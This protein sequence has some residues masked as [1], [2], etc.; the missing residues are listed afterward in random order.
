MAE[1][2]ARNLVVIR[3]FR[4]SIATAQ[5]NPIQSFSSA[6]YPLCRLTGSQVALFFVQKTE[7]SPFPAVQSCLVLIQGWIVKEP[8]GM[9]KD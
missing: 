5:I 7:E 6:V 1:T 2:E 9:E 8:T 3:D 4:K